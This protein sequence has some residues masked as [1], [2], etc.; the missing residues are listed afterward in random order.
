MVENTSVPDGLDLTGGLECPRSGCLF[1]VNAARWRGK[2][3]NQGIME[4]AVGPGF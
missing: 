3:A 4:P 1:A 2:N